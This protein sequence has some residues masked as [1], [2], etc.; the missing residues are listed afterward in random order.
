MFA[1][2]A[3]AAGEAMGADARP[4]VAPPTVPL[5][6]AVHGAPAGAAPAPAPASSTSPSS[7]A[8]KPAPTPTSAPAATAAQAPTP[9]STPP[10]SA[11]KPAATGAHAALPST[12]ASGP[13]GSVLVAA[14]STAGTTPPAARAPAARKPAR[15]QIGPS[16]AWAEKRFVYRADNKRLGDVLQDFAASQSLPA[17]VAEDLEGVVNGNF[18]VKIDVFLDSMARTYNFLWYH[19]GSA[20]YFYPG[21]AMQSRMFRLKGFRRQQVQNLLQS[22]EIGDKR[23]P[24]R[25]DEAQNTLYV[26]GPPRHVELV[27]SAI[28]TLD[29]GMA[30]A[31]LRSVQVFPLRFASAG[32]RQVGGVTVVGVASTLRKLFATP[33][34]N[35]AQDILALMPDSSAEVAEMA[36][37]TKR[38]IQPLPKLVGQKPAAPKPTGSSLGLK[39]GGKG[40]GEDDL[41]P[42]IEAD[43]GT[44]S[45]VIQGRSDR[46]AEYGALIARLDQKPMLV[47]LVAT[48]IEVS[49]DSVD[50]LGINWSMKNT[51]GNSLQLSGPQGAAGRVDG[52]GLFTLG[53]V[54]ANAG[55]E[56]LARVD[57]LQGEGKARIVSRPS[58]L[59]VANRTAVMREKR[60]ATVRVSGSRD[61]NLYQ[62]EAGTL[63]EMTPQVT[64]A[65]GNNRI[66]LSIYIEDGNFEAGQI[67]QI[68]IVKK[69]EIRT[70]AH[71][72]EGES[73]LIAGITIESDKTQR[74]G[75]PGLQ[76][77]PL[78]GG[79]F[80][81]TDNRAQR[82]ERMFLITPRLPGSSATA[83]AAAQERARANAILQ[84]KDAATAVSATAPAG[85]PA[86][87]RSAAP[88]AGHGI[89]AGEFADGN[90]TY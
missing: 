36:E 50:Q 55:R 81:S 25:Y 47:E 32:D 48:I 15:V 70:E 87:A 30:E 7:P 61:A 64:H 74:N 38:G 17:V 23:Y 40:K 5:Y 51:A 3:L 13:A 78:V 8:P 31:A 18:D 33:G 58:V 14:A 73:L 60:V 2:M 71:V 12:A 41:P 34:T 59:G 29:A 77:A 43:E 6:M 83:A 72:R 79:L 26:S 16:S 67:D 42:Q 19:D 82:T 39:P 1:A 35:S 62:V 68:P 69:T 11:A 56:L 90:S 88:A 86:P 9:A 76:H 89:P 75:V 80:R 52:L 24:I 85:T 84:S 45:V 21:R 63:L 44:N 49:S 22:L 46:M 4:P 66:K 27:T 28:E 53:T 54:V 65:D 10:P 20:L 57:A 37:R